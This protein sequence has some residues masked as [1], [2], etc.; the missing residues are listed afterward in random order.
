M[1]AAK[2]NKYPVFRAVSKSVSILTDHL[3]DFAIL[4]ASAAF[5]LMILSFVFAQ[6]FICMLPDL[7][8]EFY[9]GVSVFGYVVY[10]LLKLFIL[11]VFLR[12][13]ADKVFL[14]KE[15]NPAYFKTNIGRFFKFFGVF[16]VFLF[17]NSLPAFALYLLIVR[18]PN[19][20]WQIELLFFLVV[21]LGFVVPFVLLRFYRNMALYIAGEPC[22]DLKQTYVK[23]NFKCSK[24]FVAFSIVLALC[25]FFFLTVNANLKMHVFEPYGMYNILAEFIFEFALCIVLA[26]GLNF[27]MVQ[28]EI[29]E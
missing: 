2:E 22:F 4:G 6:S 7:R 1:M 18:V 24:I 13:W 8:A 15:I 10:A 12:L 28:K 17:L 27:L 3:K 9:C 16:L 29:L 14:Q 23:T 5:A 26:V 19:P 25:L 21:S 11:A 20:I